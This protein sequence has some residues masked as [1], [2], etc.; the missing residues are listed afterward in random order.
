MEHPD[1]LRRLVADAVTADSAEARWSA[2]AAVP[3]SLVEALLHAGMQ[4]GN[5][6]EL[7][8]TGVAASPGAASGILCLTAEAVLDAEDRGE[9]AVL[10]RDETTPADEIGMQL[11]EGIVTAR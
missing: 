8:G 4:G 6:L 1:D 2:V 10:V 3:P 5:Y 11:A 9:P 7:L